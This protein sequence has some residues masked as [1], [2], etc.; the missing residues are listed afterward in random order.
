[1]FALLIYFLFMRYQTQE[2][3]LTEEGLRT[4]Y[5]GQERRLRWDD[6]RIFAMYDAQGIKKSAFAQTY[7]L[8]NE[9]TVVR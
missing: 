9:Q 6:T 7:E 1:M 5:M 8:S 3:E 4:R 2:I